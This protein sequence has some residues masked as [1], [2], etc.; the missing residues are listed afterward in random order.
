M[1]TYKAKNDLKSSETFQ[2]DLAEMKTQDLVDKTQ[3]AMVAIGAISLAFFSY[4]LTSAMLDGRALIAPLDT[5]GVKGLSAE[6]V[7]MLLGTG[8]ITIV[9]FNLLGDDRRALRI[10]NNHFKAILTYFVIM[11]SAVGL[12]G[13]SP[14]FYEILV[15]R[16]ENPVFRNLFVF[17]PYVTVCMGTFSETLESKRY[18]ENEIKII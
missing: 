17:L 10:L 4:F 18:S 15:T 14:V 1:P 6:C 11:T 13:V 3:R 7:P 16:L 12:L 5:P 2:N 8:A 9:S